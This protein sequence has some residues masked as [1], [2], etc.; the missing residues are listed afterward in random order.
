MDIG[1]RSAGACRRSWHRLVSGWCVGFS[2]AIAMVCLAQAR[3]ETTPTSLS[4][5]AARDRKELAALD[6][7]YKKAPAIS[8][9][10][11]KVLKLGL[12]GQERKSDGKIWISKGR[13]R[14]EL[15][16]SA[17]SLLVVN[18]KNFWAVS[19]PSAEFKG[20]ALQV[21]K[22]E[23][24]TKKG[25]SQNFVS[26]LTEGGISKYFVATGVEGRPSGEKTY[27]LQPRKDQIDL[28][29]AQ[30]TLSSNGKFISEIRFWDEKD[31]ETNFAFSNV[32]FGTKSHA[33]NL[34][35]YTPPADADVMS[36]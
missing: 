16:G 7:R 8:A 35:T 31:N 21:I 4:P 25:R 26:L 10:V 28:K 19:F 2:V 33:D 34:F 5:V 17:K 13:M 15:D 18:K 11:K 27:F 32:V 14:L 1:T 24:S 3:A 6:E 30:L 23:T 36:Y 12:L 20:A 22:G 29:R 9:D